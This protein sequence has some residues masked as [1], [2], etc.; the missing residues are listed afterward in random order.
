MTGEKLKQF[1]SSTRVLLAQV[2]G[3]T[4]VAPAFWPS[5]RHLQA[6][7][8][9]NHADIAALASQHEWRVVATIPLVSHF[10]PLG[11]CLRG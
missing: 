3:V 11:C 7:Q 8:Q 4:D 6:P 1:V 9:A 2:N 10:L 5:G